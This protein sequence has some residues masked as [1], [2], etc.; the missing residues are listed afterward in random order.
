M[1]LSQKFRTGQFVFFLLVYDNERVSH[2]FSPIGH[3]R[4]KLAFG[5]CNRLKLSQAISATDTS[6]NIELLYDIN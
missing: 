5:V 3:V 6:Y 2:D 4:T 1:K